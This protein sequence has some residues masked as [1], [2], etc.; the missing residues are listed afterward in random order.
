MY[1]LFDI[2]Q[3]L[4]NFVFMQNTAVRKFQFFVFMGIAHDLYSCAISRGNYDFNFV[5]RQNCVQ[6]KFI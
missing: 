5:Y 3:I 4:L 6:I 2:K 1:E